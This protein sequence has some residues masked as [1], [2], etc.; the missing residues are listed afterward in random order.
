MSGGQVLTIT[1]RNGQ[2]DKRM[3]ST[4]T[5]IKRIALQIANHDLA[6]SNALQ[7]ERDKLNARL[8][9]I[10]CSIT[11]ARQA[12]ERARAF[13]PSHGRDLLC[14]VCWV[15]RNQQAALR[16]IANECNIFECPECGEQIDVPL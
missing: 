14:P 4:E 5:R 1:V 3:S 10:D 7:A 8:A 2:G 6:N 11:V 12:V 15:R 9:Q 16:R 13:S